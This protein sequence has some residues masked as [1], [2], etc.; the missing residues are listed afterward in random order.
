M[1]IENPLWGAPK[2]HGELLKLGIDIAQSTVSITMVPKQ[3]R[4]LQSDS[5]ERRRWA[6]A[7]AKSWNA[8]RRPAV[9]VFPSFPLPKRWST[10]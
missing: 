6:R 2:I 1:S 3:G 4:P 5:G 7:R 10:V 9:G 8:V